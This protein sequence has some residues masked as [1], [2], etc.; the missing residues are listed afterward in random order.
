MVNS[1]Q[2]EEVQKQRFFSEFSVENPTKTYRA[3]KLRTKY[4]SA[5]IISID[6]SQKR[7][8]IEAADNLKKNKLLV[9]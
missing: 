3:R 5:A 6:N 9:E 2:T 8:K 4:R 7:L 1:L